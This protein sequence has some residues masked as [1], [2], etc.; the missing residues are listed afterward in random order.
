MRKRLLHGTAMLILT[1]LI[2]CDCYTRHQ[3][4][5]LDSQTEQPIIN[6]TIIFPTGEYKTDSLG[7]FQIK[8]A[9]GFCPDWD[10]EIKKDKYKPEK[11]LIDLDDNEVIYRVRT[12]WD[13]DERRDLTSMNFKIKNDTLYFYLTKDGD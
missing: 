8:E 1:T 11:I 7:Y 6:A 4:F 2:S 9:T 10:F 12:D 3:G 5:V 13:K